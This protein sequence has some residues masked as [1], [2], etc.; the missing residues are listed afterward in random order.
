MLTINDDQIKRYESDLKT[1]AS[2]A[3]PF[4]TKTTI[5]KA[6]FETRTVSQGNIRE[7]MIT[8]NKFSVGSIRVDQARTLKVSRQ[9]A[10]VG[11]VAPYM[12][13][14][15]FGGTKAK[16]G[17]Q[18]VAIPTSVASG[19]GEGTQP[20]QRLPR[21]PNRLASIKLSRKKPKV[22]SKKQENFLRIQ[23]AATS[24]RKFIFLDLQKHPGIYKV[25]GGK[26]R[27][28]IK[29]MYDMSKKSVS[30]PRN[31]WL[32]PAVK[33]VEKKIPEFYKDALAFQ[34]KRQGIFKPN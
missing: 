11:S 15:E 16:K 3:Y 29:L 6:A 12:A 7:N 30:I 17:K 28:N 8:R 25:T 31:P 20:R 5:N 19:E 14:Q 21:V 33:T 4:A 26:R 9:A 13:V 34:L 22:R 24:G 32:S 10:T 27:P 18:G 23:A 2:R 1:F